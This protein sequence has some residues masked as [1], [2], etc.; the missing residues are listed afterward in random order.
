MKKASLLKVAFIL[1]LMLVLN[2]S[3]YSQDALPL[4]YWLEIKPF[5]ST[6]KEVDKMFLKGIPG[7][8]YKYLVHYKSSYGG[9][10]VEYSSGNCTYAVDKKVKIPEWTVIKVTYYTDDDAPELKGFLKALGT[11]KTGQKGA[12][13]D[14]IYYSN[15][16]KGISII[17]NKITRNIQE[18]HISPSPKQEN[19]YSCEVNQ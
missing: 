10:S 3:L 4:D 16:E 5:I 7:L 1:L 2:N 12:V 19:Q 8:N 14:H 18:I 15:E 13:I 17:Y 9:A 6:K 11:Y